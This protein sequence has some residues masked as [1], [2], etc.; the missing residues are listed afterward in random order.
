MAVIVAATLQTLL[1]A[2]QVSATNMENLIDLAVDLLNLEGADLPN[3]SGT[4]GSKTLS[5]ESTEK[6]AIFLAARAIYHSDPTQFS[7]AEM[8]INSG[9]LLSNPEVMRAIKAA[10]CSIRGPQARVG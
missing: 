10:A 9:D 7:L 3:M 8:N 1:N 4:A 6:A 2:L 5:V